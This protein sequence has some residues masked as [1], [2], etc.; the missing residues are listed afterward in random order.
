MRT[1]LLF[2]VF[3]FF[4]P[5][6]P[7]AQ[8]QTGEGLDSGFGTDGIVLT[9]IDGTHQSAAVVLPLPD[10]GVI[11]VGSTDNTATG[12]ETHSDY[13]VVRIDASRQSRH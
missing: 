4:F 10:G 2:L 6:L 11:V 13:A 8:A 3:V 1:S 7:M 5:A 9:D 12:P